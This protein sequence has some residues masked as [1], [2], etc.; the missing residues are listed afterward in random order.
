MST[1]DKQLS[2]LHGKL[3]EDVAH[4]FSL[5]K[6]KYRTEV[7]QGPAEQSKVGVQ[8]GLYNSSPC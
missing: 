8:I 3:E 5:T 4:L 6:K 1:C 7:K 2:V